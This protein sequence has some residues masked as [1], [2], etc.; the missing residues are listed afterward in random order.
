VT[1]LG[2]LLRTTA[3]KL[4]LAFLVMFAVG[5]GLLLGRVGFNVRNL[6]DEQISGTLEA[7]LTGLAEQYR[8]SPLAPAR[9]LALSRHDF[10]R[11]THRRQHRAIAA[12]RARYARRYRDAIPARR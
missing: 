2:K 1:A 8:Q 7:E 4:S 6:I 11:R 5:A 10:R 3:F 9:R 12:R